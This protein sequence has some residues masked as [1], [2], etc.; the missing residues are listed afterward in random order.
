MSVYS[1][2]IYIGSGLSL[3][4]GGLVI[5]YFTNSGPWSLPGV[6]VVEP[7]QMVFIAIAAPVIPLTLMLFTVAEPYRRGLTMIRDAAGKLRSV[8]EPLPVVGQYVKANA[9]TFALHN[10]GFGLLALSGYASAAWAPSFFIR[11]HGLTIGEVG[12]RLGILTIIFG[13][14]GIVF[15]GVLADWLMKRGYRDAKIRVAMFA[16]FLRL[17]SGI[18]FTQVESSNVALMLYAPSVFFVSMPFGVG[19]AAI[20]EMM[21][22]SMRGQGSA[23]YLFVVNLLG[24]GLGPY[25]LPA[26]QEEFFSDSTNPVREGLLY[27]CTLSHVIA[28]FALLFCMAPFRR[29]LDYLQNYK[30][31]VA[32]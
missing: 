27:V 16:A 13:T 19:P 28:G 23:I 5:D 24:L 15:G 2:G 17:P 32:S 12:T 22:P 11:E 4:F 3:L 30:K 21:P 8:K 1:M 9:Q 20:Q 18:L 25:I 6:G 26:I 7:W 14:A 10:F 31:A 29:S